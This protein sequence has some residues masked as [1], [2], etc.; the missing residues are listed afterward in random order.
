MKNTSQQFILGLLVKWSVFS[1]S[2]IKQTFTRPSRSNSQKCYSVD[3]C[4]DTGKPQQTGK[5]GSVFFLIFL[6]ICGEK[7]K[8]KIINRAEIRLSHFTN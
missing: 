8:K 2:K 4:E 3:Q 6:D 5:K 7:K 1:L